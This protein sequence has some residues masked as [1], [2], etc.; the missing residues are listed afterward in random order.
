[1]KNLHGNVTVLS[2]TKQKVA[3]MTYVNDGEVSHNG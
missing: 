1:M 3:T 2:V